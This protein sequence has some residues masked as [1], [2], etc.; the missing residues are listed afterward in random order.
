MFNSIYKFES[1]TSQRMPDLPHQRSL[2]LHK[3][4]Q[5]RYT[6]MLEHSGQ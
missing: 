2:Y 1:P 4:L 3:L 6:T 5:Q